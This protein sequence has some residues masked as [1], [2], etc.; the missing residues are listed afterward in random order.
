MSGVKEKQ[1]LDTW[2]TLVSQVVL[3]PVE[4][5]PA[6]EAE[7][8]GLGNVRPLLGVAV[9][10]PG[11]VRFADFRGRNVPTEASVKP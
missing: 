3:L 4:D 9:A 10:V 5:G 8:A 2:F 1:T 11:V 7:R 6:L